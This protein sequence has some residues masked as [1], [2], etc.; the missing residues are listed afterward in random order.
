METKCFLVPM[1]TIYSSNTPQHYTSQ[2]DAFI[3]I[4]DSSFERL[5]YILKL[6]S[7][8]PFKVIYSISHF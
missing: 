1:G 5:I 7:E 8:H 3:L 4:A 2:L 6:F